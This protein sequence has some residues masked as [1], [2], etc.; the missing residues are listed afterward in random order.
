MRTRKRRSPV[1]SP[2]TVLAKFETL[3]LGAGFNYNL[4]TK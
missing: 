3:K 2:A 1:R 4:T